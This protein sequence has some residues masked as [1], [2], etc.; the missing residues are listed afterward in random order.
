[1]TICLSAEVPR[2]EKIHRQIADLVE[3]GRE[4][5]LATVVATGGSSPRGIASKMLILPDGETSGSVGGGRLE[6]F[7]LADAAEALASGKSIL[8]QYRLET[9]HEGGIGMICGGNVDVF[10]EVHPA[11]RTLLICGGGHV[12]LALSHAAAQ[13]GLPVTVID[14]REEY[15]DPARFP[16][17]TRVIHANPESME[18][19]SAVNENTYAIITTHTHELDFAALRNLLRRGAAY[20]GMIGS[21]R[22]IKTIMTKLKEE[23]FEDGELAQVHTPIGIDIGAETPAEIAVSILAEII[24]HYRKGDTSPESMREKLDA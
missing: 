11:A 10:I 12:G 22:K 9:E 14:P 16:A 24:R 3:A 21:R 18:A 23:G 7:V 13:A 20:V 19:A 15:A 1:M 2:V 5:A 8:K 17:G 6:K 4:F